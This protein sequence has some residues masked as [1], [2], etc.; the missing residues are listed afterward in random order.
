VIAIDG[1]VRRGAGYWLSS[2]R[3]MLR[4]ELT[5]LRTWVVIALLIQLLMSTGMVF[6]YGFYFGDMPSEV[7]TF[8]VTGI[9]A[10]AL[11]PIGFVLV[12]GMIMQRKIRDTYDFISSLP[13]PRMVS[14]AATFTIASAIG[15][16]GTALALWIANLRY[17][18]AISLSAAAVVAVLLVSLMA[19]SVGFAFGHAIPD[20]RVANLLTNL[21]VFLVLL[22][23]PIVVPIDLFPDWWA[24]VHRVLPFWHMAVVV[25][26]GLTEGLVSTSVS[27]SYMVLGAWTVGSWLLAAWVVGRRK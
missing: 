23:S 21:I 6:M 17:E 2:Y 18:V 19:S 9:P 26:A 3:S 22:F 16:P 25:R 12:P 1:A 27:A 14:A 10:L 7:Q 5:N 13:V 8:L 15:I 24:A 11:V 4:F 20:P